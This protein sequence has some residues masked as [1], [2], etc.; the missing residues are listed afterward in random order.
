MPT[1][2]EHLLY[3]RQHCY[4]PP[5]PEEFTQEDAA[6][7][8]RFGHWLDALSRGVIAPITPEQQRFLQVMRGE[9]EPAAAL[10]RIWV[11]VQ[12]QQEAA[13]ARLPTASVGLRRFDE[14]GAVEARLAELLEARQCAAD[15]AKQR[16]AERDAVLAAVRDQLDAVE[17]KY[18]ARLAGANQLV[19]DLEEAVKEGVLRLGRSV[20]VGDV[21]AI[22]NRGRTTWDSKGLA[23]YAQYNPEVARFRKVGKPAAYIRYPSTGEG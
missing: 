17:A 21:R 4:S 9:A 10:E 13:R 3:L 15:V 6:L 19:R 11:E 8:S 2:P 23:D 1:P 5:V 20:Q 12:R 7:L 14:R 18:A 22:F 16:D